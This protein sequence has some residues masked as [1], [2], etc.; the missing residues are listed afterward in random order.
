MSSYLSDADDE[1]SGILASLARTSS[2]FLQSLLKRAPKN[3]P[4][5][6]LPVKQIARIA[7]QGSTLK[8]VVDSA[9]AESIGDVYKR[10][11]W[12]GIPVAAGRAAYNFGKAAALGAVLFETYDHI[13]ESAAPGTVPF[14]ALPF[15]AGGLA[16]SAHA[17][18]SALVD[19]GE[20]T[21]LTRA[22]SLT[23]PFPVHRLFHHS[24]THSVLFGSFESTKRLL[25][26]AVE[27]KDVEGG[28][29]VV[30]NVS[31]THGCT[32]AV[33]GGI[34]GCL[35]HVASHYTEIWEE[36]GSVFFNNGRALRLPP[37]QLRAVGAAFLP[38]ALGFVAFEYAKSAYSDL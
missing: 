22:F 28:S 21:A 19:T 33:A 36:T 18:A 38:S 29:E 32:V 31:V 1:N 3:V 16:G 5:G 30:S 20:R 10:Q 26:G 23:P 9:S 24:I 13:I 25:L 15:I 27:E 4:I 8:D 17:G 35:S 12:R 14:H 2:R 6:K 34:A 37:I 11:G 7:D